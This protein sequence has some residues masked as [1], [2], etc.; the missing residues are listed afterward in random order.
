VLEDLRRRGWSDAPE[1]AI[2]WLGSPFRGLDAYEFQHAP[3]FYRRDAAR[4]LPQT[5]YAKT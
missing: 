4:P 5:L 3:I 1:P 2:S